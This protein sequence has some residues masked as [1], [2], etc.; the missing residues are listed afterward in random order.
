MLADLLGYIALDVHHH[1]G[2]IV[3]A[4]VHIRALD[5][6]ICTA[7]RV[8]KTRKDFGQVVFAYHVRQAIGAQKQA[9]T[10]GNVQLVNVGHGINAAAQ[11]AR[12]NRA[13][14]VRFRFFRRD[15]ARFDKQRHKR[16][17][18]RDLLQVALVQKV[19]ARVAHLRNKQALSLDHSGGER[20]AH[21]FGAMAVF[22]GAH[23]GV[24]GG[25]HGVGQGVGVQRCGR[26]L[27]K[28]GY[29]NL[30]CHFAGFVSAHAI[31]HGVQRRRCHV[32]IFVVIAHAAHVGARAVRGNGAAVSFV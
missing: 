30:R 14:R 26:L 11:R 3:V 28:H 19:G 25:D 16:V 12:D 24:V 7:L 32:V 5:Q 6:L 13:L 4:A 15:L 10:C 2:N 21:A 18:A 17:V 1:G 23:D 22:H 31:G 29:G 9:V 20:A 27:F 8:A